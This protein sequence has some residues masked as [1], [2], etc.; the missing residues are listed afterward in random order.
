MIR[1]AATID[2]RDFDAYAGLFCEEMELLMPGSPPT[3]SRE[4]LRRGLEKRP[5]ELV[6]RHVITNP[7]VEVIDGARARGHCY[8]TLYRTL[9]PAGERGVHAF[10][11]P[12]AVGE[13]F[14][15][16]L[17]TNEGWRIRRRELRFVFAVDPMVSD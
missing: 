12:A 2:A 11:R 1:Y 4:K 3:T 17:R 5:V 16:Y 15:D 7:L 10:S 8:L 6:S 14:D 13:Y 9:A